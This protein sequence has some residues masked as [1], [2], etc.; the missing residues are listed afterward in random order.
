VSGFQKH[1]HTRAT[2]QS[3]GILGIPINKQHKLHVNYFERGHGQMP[4]FRRDH[5]KKLIQ[6]SNTY[7]AFIA[8]KNVDNI[9]DFSTLKI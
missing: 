9:K 2:R 3:S 5:A 8:Y 4:L 7:V 6:S 1:D